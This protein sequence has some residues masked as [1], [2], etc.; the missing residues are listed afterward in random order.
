[1]SPADRALVGPLAWTPQQKAQYDVAFFRGLARDRQAQRVYLAKVRI[2][3]TVRAKAPAQLCGGCKDNNL[4]KGA[5]RAGARPL[6]RNGPPTGAAAENRK[7]RKKSEAQRQ[8]GAQKLQHSWQR[9]C[10]AAAAKPGGSPPKILARVLACC[11][12]FFELL[13]PEGAERMQR[14]RDEQQAQSPAMEVDAG[15]AGLNAMRRGRGGGEEGGSTSCSAD[16]YWRA[17][18][19]GGQNQQY[20]DDDNCCARSRWAGGSGEA[21]CKDYAWRGLPQ[22]WS[23]R[24]PTPP[25]PIPPPTTMPLPDPAT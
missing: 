5:G 25:K 10:E 23:A 21:A 22:R 24:T 17:E 15:E 2:V 16:G 13:L 18:R 9:R 7:R 4:C 14:L 19:R 3:E 6:G 1:M 20:N 8:K 11:G 12:R